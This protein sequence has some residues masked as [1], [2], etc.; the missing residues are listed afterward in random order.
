MQI[1][2]AE[3][4]FCG[5]EKRPMVVGATSPHKSGSLACVVRNMQVIRGCVAHTDGTLCIVC[6]PYLYTSTTSATQPP[7]QGFLHTRV[8]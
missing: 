4:R 6:T 1:L 2:Y 7:W 3:M 5:L 8:V